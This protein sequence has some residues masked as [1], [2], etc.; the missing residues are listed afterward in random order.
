MDGKLAA[1][2][3]VWER[4]KRKNQYDPGLKGVLAFVLENALPIRHYQPLGGLCWQNDG[5]RLRS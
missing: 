2:S 4:E 3:P 1:H 5:P